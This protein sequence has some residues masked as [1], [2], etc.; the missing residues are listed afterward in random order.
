M[1]KNLAI[2][3]GFGICVGVD[4]VLLVERREKLVLKDI[5]VATGEASYIPQ[6]LKFARAHTPRE[7]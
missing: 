2:M 7:S 3:G 4:G 1:V 6:T 5:E